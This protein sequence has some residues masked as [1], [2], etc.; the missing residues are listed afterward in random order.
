M[1]KYGYTGFLTIDADKATPEVK[2]VD[3]NDS[4]SFRLTPKGALFA[5]L[6]RVFG[7]SNSMKKSVEA[8]HLLAEWVASEAMHEAQRDGRTTTG[9]EYPAIVFAD[10][11]YVI[12]V[13]ADKAPDEEE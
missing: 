1:N 10:S 9:E 8:Y 7:A 6:N 5:V 2:Y 11:G 3:I 13:E 12:T 4:S